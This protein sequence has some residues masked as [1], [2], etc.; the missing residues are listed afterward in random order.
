MLNV[1]TSSDPSNEE[2]ENLGLDSTG[3]G[4][5]SPT[6]QQEDTSSSAYSTW[7][8]G[9]HSQLTR[10]DGILGTRM[11]VGV[12]ASSPAQNGE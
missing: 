8:P 12:N 6:D 2:D 1:A 4:P 3:P 9:A 10:G 11:D 7:G 5:H